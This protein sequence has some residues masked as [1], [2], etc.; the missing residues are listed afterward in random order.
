ML[1]A[2]WFSLGGVS[3][4]M[5]PP[6]PG[7]SHSHCAHVLGLAAAL[8]FY[9]MHWSVNCRTRTKGPVELGVVPTSNHTQ[10]EGG[11]TPLDHKLFSAQRSF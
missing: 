5:H 8:E 7:G 3:Y 6:T 4:V 11:E 10:P 2:P 1:L 9:P